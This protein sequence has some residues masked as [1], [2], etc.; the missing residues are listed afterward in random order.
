MNKIYFLLA[1]MLFF[2]IVAKKS[3][4]Q[5]E[6]KA[7]LT[8]FYPI[9]SSGLSSTDHNYKFS[10]NTIYGM[11]GGV[12]G[13]ELGSVGNIV[14]GNV[15]G[16]QLAGVFNIVAAKSTTGIIQA[17]ADT[18][19]TMNGVQLAGVSNMV[20]GNQKGWQIAGVCNTT[21]ENSSG[22]VVS[23][24]SNI[25]RK[26]VNGAMVSGV[27]N[28]ARTLKG[29]QLS[30]INIATKRVKG[31][32]IGVVNITPR[33]KGFQLG[34][35]NIGQAVSDSII[36]LGV[37]N[38]FRDGYYAFE[39]STDERLF[40]QIS[41]KMGVEKLYTIFQFGVNFRNSTQ[42]YSAGAGLGT[43]FNITSKHKINL[44]LITTQF[45]EHDFKYI[46]DFLNQA[47]LDY[48]YD[49]TKHIAL[50]I[51]PTFNCYIEKNSKKTTDPF[52]IPYSIIEGKGRYHTTSLWIGANA[53]VVIKL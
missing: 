6:K 35:V 42:F 22:V 31:A 41:Y 11:T 24:L 20:K 14:K 21:T 25:T 51:G 46:P 29:L 32:Q 39:L 17:T 19:Q 15:N 30:T 37:I 36:P 47:N 48:Q 26:D 16:F 27:F 53:G 1:T 7:Q 49:L 50:K 45:F 4:A 2:L 23:G 10:F 9:G 43:I 40:S 28:S 44:E 3:E 13:F 18:S 33:G 52:R 8:F 12:N 5:T 38:I 34:V